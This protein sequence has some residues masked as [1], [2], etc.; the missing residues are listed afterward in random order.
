MTFI[1][2]NFHAMTAWKINPSIF[3]KL[4]NIRSKPYLSMH[5]KLCNV[6]IFLCILWKDGMLSGSWDGMQKTLS[7][8]SS[9][10]F[11]QNMLLLM[12]FLYER[13]LLNRQGW[14][15]LESYI[16]EWTNERGEL[17]IV[18]GAIFE[19]KYEIMVTV[20]MPQHISIRW[21]SIRM[22]RMQSHF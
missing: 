14:R 19:G 3:R 17:Y 4:H 7:L 9:E 21:L 2:R 13:P 10:M 11:V 15:Y 12:Q 20:S 8:I 22:V 6:H 5:M 18:T 1:K 16:R